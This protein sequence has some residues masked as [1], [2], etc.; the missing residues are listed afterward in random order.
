MESLIQRSLWK[1]IKAVR[2]AP[3]KPVKSPP[4]FIK[5]STSTIN[6]GSSLALPR[7]HNDVLNRFLTVKWAWPLAF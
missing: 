5:N 1:E 3:C 4:T 7:R 2:R 6:Q